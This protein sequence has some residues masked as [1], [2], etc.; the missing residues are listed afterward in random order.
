MKIFEEGRFYQLSMQKSNT[1]DFMRAYH[2]KIG[3]SYLFRDRLFDQ[4][5]NTHLV[6][7]FRIFFVDFVHPKV[8]DEVEEFEMSGEE[9]AYEIN[10]PFL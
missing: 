5:E 4:G 7:V 9:F 8:I 6:R 10:A 1:V 2:A 3:H